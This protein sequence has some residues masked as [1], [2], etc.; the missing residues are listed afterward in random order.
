MALPNNIRFIEEMD[1]HEKAKFIAKN[2]LQFIDQV[3]KKYI[4]HL[5]GKQI[6]LYPLHD[7]LDTTAWRGFLCYE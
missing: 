6:D 1:P 4:Y 5:S 7:K 2:F 3:V